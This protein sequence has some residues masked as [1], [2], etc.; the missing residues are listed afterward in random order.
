MGARSMKIAGFSK[1]GQRTAEPPVTWL[2]STALVR[3]QVISLAA[4]F[5]DSETL[6][7]AEARRL[8]HALLGSPKSARAALQYGTTKGDPELRRIAAGRLA[9]QDAAAG[10]PGGRRSVAAGT[11]S[12]ERLFITTGSQQLLYVVTEC[13]CDPGDIV[14]VEDPTYFV[15][16]GIIQSHGLGCR[17]IRL[18]GSGL[19]LAHLEQVLENL[20]RQGNIRRLKLL[21][22]V[23]YHQNPTG[24]STDYRRK[25]GA[26]ELLRRYER[27][28]GHPIYVL[29]DAAYRELRFAGADVASAL[30]LPHARDR[31]IYAGTF[32]KTFA[33]GVRV[34]FGLL[35]EVLL[36]VVLRVKGNHDFG[37]SNLLQQLLR[38]ALTTNCYDR[39]LQVLRRRYAQKAEG[40]VRALQQ[41][42]PPAVEWT[43]PDGGLYIWAR[44]PAT[45]KSGLRSPLFHRALEHDVL[46]VPGE[47]CYAPDPTRPRPNRE[48]RLS[49][50]G[51]TVSDIRTGI[52]RLG[53]TLHELL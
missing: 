51:A 49:F 43:Q 40:M 18:T 31:V 53:A 27:P 16:L 5:T 52:A 10:G 3:P 37:T 29:E 13:L 17:G 46:Y 44:L 12:P 1:L 11:Y 42:F 20:R 47:L 33:T 45:L 8:L 30:T 15:Y 6:P 35:P 7:V 24:L 32:S 2:M 4:G 39:H 38:R 26:L 14:L 41:H 9:A 21:Y 36:R 48:M 22:L 34:G 19:D 23:T 50:G 25:A 28:A